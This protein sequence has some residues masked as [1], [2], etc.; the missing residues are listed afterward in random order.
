MKPQVGKMYWINVC[1]KGYSAKHMV[2]AGDKHLL[3]AGMMCYYWLE[4]ADIMAEV[5]EDTVLISEPQPLVTK[6]GAYWLPW[7][8]K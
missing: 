3:N 1:G 8:R 2:S 7:R 4:E 6:P 5:E